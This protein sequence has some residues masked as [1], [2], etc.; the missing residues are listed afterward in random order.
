M[1][2][3]QKVTVAGAYSIVGEVLKW[4]GYVPDQEQ[5]VH[6]IQ[7]MRVLIAWVPAAMYLI[8]A[9]ILLRFPFTRKVHHEIQQALRQK[10]ETA[11]LD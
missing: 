4:I 10:R 3:L 2:F 7:G 11:N 8:A 1:R 5:A 9:V 6:T